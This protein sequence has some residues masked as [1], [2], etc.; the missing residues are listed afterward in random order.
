[1]AVQGGPYKTSA[2]RVTWLMTGSGL[3]IGSDADCHPLT[4]SGSV[5]SYGVTWADA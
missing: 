2:G 1:M 4:T 3:I 5:T